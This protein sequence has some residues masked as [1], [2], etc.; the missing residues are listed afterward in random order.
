VPAASRPLRQRVVDFI[1]DHLGWIP[2]LGYGFLLLVLVGQGIVGLVNEIIQVRSN[3]ERDAAQQVRHQS[4]VREEMELS[5]RRERIP[6]DLPPL[7]AEKE[8][9]ILTASANALCYL[10]HTD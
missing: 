2:A 5:K 9:E 8:R 10:R 4:C 1:D 3:I 6:T 7:T